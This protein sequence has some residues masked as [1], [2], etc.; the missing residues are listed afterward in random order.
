MPESSAD[1]AADTSITT[2]PS[3]TSL[4]P[5]SCWS[6]NTHRSPSRSAS[7]NANRWVEICA[8]APATNNLNAAAERA[9]HGQEC[10]AGQPCT[11][12]SGREAAADRWQRA[13]AIPGPNA[14]SN[15]VHAPAPRR[16][17]LVRRQ[18]RQTIC[19]AGGS[20]RD[21]RTTPAW[22]R[23]GPLNRDR[24]PSRRLSRCSGAH[25]RSG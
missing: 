9:L 25:P 6:V 15:G 10:Q 1:S 24:L 18:Y 13:K 14:A 23:R 19:W 2:W 7:T 3:T 16:C 12:S 20:S 5:W 22:V 21:R 4:F 11:V 8:S 17:N